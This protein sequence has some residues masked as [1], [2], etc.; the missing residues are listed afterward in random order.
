MENQTEIHFCTLKLETCGF[1]VTPFCMLQKEKIIYFSAPY[2][3]KEDNGFIIYGES[4]GIYSDFLN[5][6][7]HHSWSKLTLCKGARGESI[8]FWVARAVPTRRKNKA[9][10]CCTI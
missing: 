4:Q 6:F 3:S 8:E 1:Y 5:F 2:L 7:S 9:D 10:I